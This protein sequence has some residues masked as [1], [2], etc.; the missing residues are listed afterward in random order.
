MKNIL[1]SILIIFT[2][3][4]IPASAQDYVVTSVARLEKAQVSVADTEVVFGVTAATKQVAVGTNSQFTATAADSWCSATVKGKAVSLGVSANS[5][6]QRR[7]TTVTVRSKDGLTQTLRVVQLGTTPEV[8]ASPAKVEI[9]DD[10]LQ[11]TIEVASSVEPV[12]KYPN[13]ISGI[14]MPKGAGT[15]VYTFKASTLTDVAER[16]DKISVSGQ[17]A[18]ATSVDVHQYTRQYPS[19]AVISDVHFGNTQGDGPMVKVPR[20]LKALS[21][22]KDLDAIFVVGDLANSGAAEQYQQLVSVFSDSA[23]FKHPIARKVF[24]MGNHDNYSG[25]YNYANELRPFNGGEPYPYDQ[26]IVIKGYPFITISPRASGASDDYNNDTG[27]K[28]YPKAVQDT[29]KKWLARA[30]KECPGKPIFVFTHVPPKYT[31]YSSWPGEGEG[32]GTPTWSMKVLNPIL[33]KYPQAVVF[34]GHSHYPLGDPRSIHQ[35]VNPKSDKQ[36]YYTVINTGSTTYAE[37]EEPCVENGGY[38]AG[39]NNVTEGL[40]VSVQPQGNVEIRRY[41]TKRNEEIRPEDRWLLKAPFDGSQFA[42]ADIRD[43]DDNVDNKPLR[44]GLPAPSF[45]AG[46]TVDV[47]VSGG[48]ATVKFKQASDSDIILRYKI[49]IINEKG[50]AE[51]CEW[52]YAGDFLNSDRPEYF[53]YT[54]S[55]LTIGKTYKVKVEAFDSYANESAP[56]T[57]EAFST[58]WDETNTT[59]AATG[60]WNFE[61]DSNLLKTVEGTSVLTPCIVDNS[62]KVTDKSSTGDV[63]MARTTGPTADKKAVTIGTNCALR[64]TT[65]SDQAMSSYTLM[66]DMKTVASRWSGILQ[67]DKNNTSDCAFCMTSSATIGIAQ[68]GYYT[69]TPTWHRVVLSVD[70]GVARLYTDGQYRGTTGDDANGRFVLSADN[71][72]LF[73][74]NNGEMGPFDVSQIAF[75]NQ[76]LTAAQIGALGAPVSEV[77]PSLTVKESE[78]TVVDRNSFSLHV[79]GTVEP[80][81]TCPDWIHLRRPVPAIGTYTYVFSVDPMSEA[82]SRS[83]DVTISGPEG[84]GLTPLKCTVTQTKTGDAVPEALGVWTFDDDDDLMINSTDAEYYLEPATIGSPDVNT[85][86]TPAEAGIVRVEGPTVDNKAV[87]CPA[88]SALSMIYETEGA[89]KNYTL[90]YDVKLAQPNAWCAM[91]QTNLK[92]TSDAALFI[93][94]D[95]AVGLYFSG[96]GYAGKL[97]ADEW[98]RVVFVVRDN[99][100]AVYIDGTLMRSGTNA[101]DR[102]QADST[103]MYLFCDNDKETADINVAEIRFWNQSLSDRQVATLGAVDYPHI[104]AHT[105]KVTLSDN[106]T[107]FSVEVSS[108]VKP[109]FTLPDW[110]S[111]VGESEPAAGTH[112][113]DFAASK[114]TVEG[115]R[116]ATI[117]VSNADG[118][119]TPVADTITVSQSNHQ[120]TPEATGRWD[121]NDASDYFTTS[122]GT[123][124]LIPATMSDLQTMTDAGE[125]DFPHVDGPADGN[126]A[127]SVNPDFCFR[128]QLDETENL[129][130]YTLLYDIMVP[131]IGWESLLQT[132]LDNTTDGDLFINKNGTIGSGG[133]ALGYGG[134]I[135]AGKWYRVVL[136]VRDGLMNVYV[137]GALVRAG[138]STSS[139]RWT[140]DKTGCWILCDNDG[141]M[142][143]SCLAGLRFW[144]TALTDLQIQKL[145][146][147]GQ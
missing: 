5:A 28:S 72:L 126:M 57:S 98:H 62:G 31:C 49:Q 7:S 110:I 27:T 47:S 25:L 143:Q 81:F 144:D 16:E 35:G 86:D 66:W 136:A 20:A 2:L 3:G 64:M 92:N 8:V 107:D 119:D 140:M 134:Q 124:K 147:A 91:L 33:N 105:R 71:C 56:I 122:E 114:M 138:T 46:T 129:T 132:S 76:P 130:N 39:Y 11:F 95:G 41:D 1:F 112:S 141:E 78:V 42:Y 97:Y 14:S 90:M 127:I 58:V 131:T 142:V 85:V 123:A 52:R 115:D 87:L 29:L 43:K 89:V 74:D 23:N 37:I 82:G 50:Y 55:G 146:S 83:G 24:M 106:A 69:I 34:S 9:V 116:Q 15:K 63:D 120:S 38:P 145:G 13:W 73:S 108:S 22:R 53:T 67:P 88:N 6:A 94:K 99:V 54:F 84:S 103:G 21:E 61:D 36:N 18:A 102:W 79:S 32:D 19:F 77:E 70:N 93:S 133:S 40:V 48:N 109:K 128:L 4:L 59:P 113:Y 121:F 100:P 125:N 80:S 135:E 26:Y 104:I 30:A 17:N 118:G 45:E 101:N 139:G 117:I 68:L 65:G 51:R 44:T 60:R 96:F 12:F 75:W 137:N 111:Y 10:Q